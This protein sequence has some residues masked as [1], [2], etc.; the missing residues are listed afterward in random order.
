M[1][2][3]STAKQRLWL[4]CL[5]F[6]VSPSAGSYEAR[7]M[8]ERAKSSGRYGDD[9]R[10]RQ[11]DLASALGVSI[12]GA[13]T[14]SDAAAKL[15]HVLLLR[16]WVY[17]VW[18]SV[19]GETATAHDQLRLPAATALALA[20]EME[21]AG[22]FEQ[23][24][25]FATTDGREADVFYRMS[26][27]AQ[28]SEPYRFA[29]ARLPQPPPR[30]REKP[31]ARSFRDDDDDDRRPARQRSRRPV[32]ASRGTGCLIVFLFVLAAGSSAS[33]FALSARPAQSA[34]KTVDNREIL[35]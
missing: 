4:T 27:K 25:P 20:R 14:C 31:S 7:D 9:P 21:A 12:D 23:V 15:Y 29:A 22:L 35:R 3:R 26:K 34:K 19:S 33:V 13:K 2:D 8:F 24:E 16:A 17:S 6:D 5:G 11:F 32:R 18:R 1:A 30:R 10:G 28:D